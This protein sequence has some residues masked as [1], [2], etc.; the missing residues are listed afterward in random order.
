MPRGGARG[1]K[2]DWFVYFGHMSSMFT[3]TFFKH[4]YLNNLISES[5]HIQT[6]GT[7]A[8][9][10]LFHDIDPWVYTVGWV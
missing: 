10:L 6:I 2:A 9:Q 3:F 8:G 5:I 1:P 7:L 4:S